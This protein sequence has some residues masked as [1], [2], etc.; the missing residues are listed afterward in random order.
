MQ[1]VDDVI[2]TLFEGLKQTGQSSSKIENFY[3]NYPKESEMKAYDKYFV[4]NRYSKGYRKGVH[5]VP[6][7]TKLS[8]REPPKY[9]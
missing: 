4:F 8:I 3:H 5:K 2:K 6:K 1:A 9:F 7:F